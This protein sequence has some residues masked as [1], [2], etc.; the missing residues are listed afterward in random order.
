MVSIPHRLRRSPS[1]FFACTLL[2]MQGC[3][4]RPL[5]KSTAA[6]LRCCQVFRG[7]C[8]LPA[9]AGGGGKLVKALA[10]P[11]PK[12]A[13]FQE[14]QFRGRLLGSHSPYSSLSVSILT[15]EK[16]GKCS[17]RHEVH[18]LEL[19]TQR[20]G[21]AGGMH[22]LSVTGHLLTSKVSGTRC[23]RCRRELWVSHRLLRAAT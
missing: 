17:C 6:W 20:A 2:E 8:F 3:L 16:R 12:P 11:W 9:A 18:A 5:P 19:P 15:A 21:V 14:G 13:G 10:S 7:L 23:M 1:C 22:S 4:L